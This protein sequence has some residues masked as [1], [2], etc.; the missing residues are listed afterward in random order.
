MLFLLFFLVFFDDTRKEVLPADTIGIVH[1]RRAVEQVG[2]T[3]ILI[4]GEML[5]LLLRLRSDLTAHLTGDIIRVIDDV[6]EVDDGRKAEDD[7]QEYHHGTTTA[8]ADNLLTPAVADDG[9][10]NQQNG[11]ENL[12]YHTPL[13][14]N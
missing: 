13:K 12:V 3:L 7:T 11:E 6:N 9:S 5:I 10:D 8:K 14:K 4:L 1:E 2:M